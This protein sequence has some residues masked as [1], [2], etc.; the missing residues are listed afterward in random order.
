MSAAARA[1]QLLRLD[2]LVERD[3]VWH[4]ADEAPPSDYRRRWEEEAATDHVR[5]AIA[6]GETAQLDYATLTAKT[7][8]VW[9]RVPHGSG[10]GTVLELGSGYGRI[11]L[12][13]ANERGATWSEYVAVDISDTMLRRLLEYRQ[14]FAPDA[15]PVHPVCA[16]ADALPLAD[17]SVDLALSSA[18]FLHMGKGFV[19]RAAAEVAR[20]L[21]PGGGFVF[22]V[23]FPNAWNPANLVPRLKPHRLRSPNFMKFWTKAEVEALVV[24][25][26]LAEKAGG[27]AVQ[28]GS[29][30]AL[31][32]RL[33]PLPVPLARRA[34]RAAERA[35]AR[36]RD[37]LTFLWTV[38]SPGFAG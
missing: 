38:T 24:D 14:R 9:Q 18:V 6:G 15:G 17:E 3:G 5:S 23:S 7:S 26:G 29:Y 2:E 25:S 1:A 31:P 30:A 20:T 19:A 4:R 10:L 11:P 28:P 36:L 35:P 16:S 34:N 8:A 22:D 32:K 33:G 12:H 27:F 13:L 21:R 37:P